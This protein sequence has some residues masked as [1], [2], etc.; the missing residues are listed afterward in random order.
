MT[1]LRDS[2]ATS[3][4]WVNLVIIFESI[5]PS[6]VVVIVGRTGFT[7]KRVHLHLRSLSLVPTYVCTLGHALA[8]QPAAVRAALGLER[9]EMLKLYSPDGRVTEGRRGH[10]EVVVSGRREGREDVLEIPT[11]LFHQSV[12]HQ[13]RWV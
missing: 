6:R 3:H 9:V 2:N 4:A 13:S 1:V 7:T 8:V 12:T 10:R 11:R 5:E